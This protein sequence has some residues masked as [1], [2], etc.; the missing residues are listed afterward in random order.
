MS[1]KTRVLNLIRRG[2]VSTVEG[3]I[4]QVRAD[5]SREH[6]RI[7]KHRKSKRRIKQNMQQESRRKNRT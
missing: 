1:L 6:S 4:K 3:A 5:E 7:F 2:K